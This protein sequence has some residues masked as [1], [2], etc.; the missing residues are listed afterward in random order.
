MSTS[1]ALPAKHSALQEPGGSKVP[2]QPPRALPTCAE[3]CLVSPDLLQSNHSP[4]SLHG[5]LDQ[6]D[7]LSA[8]AGGSCRLGGPLGVEGLGKG[9]SVPGRSL[10]CARCCERGLREPGKGGRW[11][12]RGDRAEPM[13]SWGRWRGG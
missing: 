4:A 3:V 5:A 6:D 10:A 13:G 11:G 12:G 9:Q 1:P 8:L 7:G 2:G